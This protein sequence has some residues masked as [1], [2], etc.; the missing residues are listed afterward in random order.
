MRT[1]L[2]TLH[3]F[4]VLFWVGGMAFSQMV[5]RPAANSLQPA[6]RVPLM[7]ET[8]GRFFKLVIVSLVLIWVS[9]WFMLAPVGMRNAPLAWH[10]MYG[11]AT[12][13]TMI[14]VAIYVMYRTQAKAK[15][16]A[17]DIAGTAAVL[18]RIRVLI[19]INFVLTSIAVVAGL[20]RA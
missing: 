8:L 5:L 18:N 4:G 17:N 16:A 7:M 2:V 1:F 15:F 11:L 20:Y 3:V 12:I 14:F 10:V 9:G 13:A 19:S 6:Q